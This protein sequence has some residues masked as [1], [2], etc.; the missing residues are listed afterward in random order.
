MNWIYR[1]A[2]SAVAV[3]A[4]AVTA[5][6]FI[7]ASAAAHA[8]TARAPASPV[9]RVLPGA[10]EIPAPGSGSA[11]SPD[12]VGN[13]T[14]APEK[15]TNWAGYVVTRKSGRFRQVVATYR[16]PKLACWNSP[17]GNSSH[18]VGLDGWG[19]SGTSATVEQDGV[20]AYCAGSNG[21][22]ARYRPWWEMFPKPETVI[23]KRVVPGN[24]MTAS[25]YYASKRHSFKLKLQNRTRGWTFSTWQKC[26][27]G[28]RCQRLTA[29]II[30][31]APTLITSSGVRLAGLAD[32]RQAD[33]GKIS[34]APGYGPARGLSTKEWYRIYRVDE[35]STNNPDRYRAWTG[36]IIRSD[37]FN[38][39]WKHEY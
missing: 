29:E 16:V 32:Y 33:Y 27:S 19:E 7:P 12:A 10:P 8:P 28:Y 21:R 20:Q 23:N 5:G 38:I 13:G 6:A 22:S 36:K 9:I 30:S 15:S 37:G 34:I 31:E 11:F 17:H 14:V 18:W 35:V 2:G 4:A 24:L 39:Y 3:T 26:V 1:A 25:V